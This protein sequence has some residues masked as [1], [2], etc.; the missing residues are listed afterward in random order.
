[1]APGECDSSV[2]G[3]EVISAADD[4]HLKQRGGLPWPAMETEAAGGGVMT[5]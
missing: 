5:P 3:P 2:H 1:M 4:T